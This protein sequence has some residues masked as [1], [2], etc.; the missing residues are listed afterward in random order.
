MGRAFNFGECFYEMAGVAALVFLGGWACILAANSKADLLG[1]AL[2]HSIGLALFIWCG[3]AHS[4]CH[5]NPAV[6]FGLVL[7]GKC[8]ASKGVFYVAFQAAG[9]FLGGGLVAFTCP[10]ELAERTGFDLGAPHLNPSFG[11]PTGMV[12][13]MFG[14]FLLVLVVLSLAGEGQ[15]AP[16]AWCIGLTVGVDI[17]CFGPITGTGVNPFRSPG[18]ALLSLKLRD[19][20][21]YLVTPFIGAALAATVHRKLFEEPFDEELKIN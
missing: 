2:V 21:V 13:E 12:L 18:P 10:R 9:S 17:L 16:F 20:A 5:F 4:G 11:L 3:A 8:E 6:T 19:G 14:T 1:V 15:A 7:S